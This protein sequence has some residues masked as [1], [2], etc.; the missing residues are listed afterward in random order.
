MD[1]MQDFVDIIKRHHFWF[2]IG[3]TALLGLVVWWLSTSSMASVLTTRTKKLD[4]DFTKVQANVKTKEETIRQLTAER[5]KL[6]D[7][8]WETWTYHFAEQQKVNQWPKERLGD[9]FNAYMVKL[10][11]DKGLDAE[12]KDDWRETYQDHLPEIARDVLFRIVD[13]RR[14]VLPAVEEGKTPSGVR[15]RPGGGMGESAGGGFDASESNLQ[16]TVDWGASREVYDAE[17]KLV[18][19]SGTGRTFSRGTSSGENSPKTILDQLTSKSGVLT[20]EEVRMAQR[21]LWI[22]KN[23]LSIIGKT[24]R[25]KVGYHNAAI[26]R[27]FTLEIG[28]DC[29]QSWQKS[30]DRL[31]LS[32]L[33]GAS[34]AGSTPGGGMGAEGMG[35]DGMDGMEIGPR[36]PG[37]MNEAAGLG[38]QARPGMGPVFPGSAAAR[39]SLEAFRFVDDNGT[40]LPADQPGPHVQ[41][42]MLPFHMAIAVKQEKISSLL[43]QFCNAGMPTIVKQI[44]INPG[45]GARIDFRAQATSAGSRGGRSDGMED[46]AQGRIGP[47]RASGSQ[48]ETVSKRDREVLLDIFGVIHVSNVPDRA[49]LGDAS[50]SETGREPGA[51]DGQ[52]P[53][54]PTAGEAAPGTTP[55]TAPPAD[56][57]PAA[58][59]PA[60]TPPAATTPATTPP[61]TTPPTT[62]PP[63][64][65]PPATPVA[66]P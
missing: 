32:K 52:V 63:A 14:E 51:A 53:V 61:A 4:G 15:P 58:T 27:I 64:T 23:L 25:G 13:V 19:A 45:Q 40:F 12:I 7:N 50:A 54:D 37:G 33:T 9:A 35:M 49:K 55:A 5:E 21:D 3:L 65:T 39:A 60:T 10:T 28:R 38:P 42:K 2:L 26:T 57:T 31:G 47:G 22:Y 11:K 66:T 8:V 24:N 18:N 34:L 36:E 46:Y 56:T 30:Q 29:M 17:G 41:F 48:Q 59:T 62:T 6:S 44:A 43:A 1:K 16:G 20:S